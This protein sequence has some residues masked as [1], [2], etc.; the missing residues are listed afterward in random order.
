MIR[1]L[2][3]IIQKFFAPYA[4][5][6]TPYAVAGF[7]LV[8]VMVSVSILALGSSLIYEAFFTNLDLCNYYED[9]L[10]ITPWIN[11]KIWQAQNSLS[12]AVSPGP[13]ETDG[14]FINGNRKFVWDLSYVALDEIKE[15]YKLYKIDLSV[16]WRVGKRPF[17][18]SRS[19][20]ALYEKRH[21]D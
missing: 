14:V 4:L 5:R 9:Y 8:E 15:D 17:A 2:S 11:E 19:A 7:T 21:S 12:R 16:N 18:L 10:S 3:R 1:K 13:I 20:Y 6:R